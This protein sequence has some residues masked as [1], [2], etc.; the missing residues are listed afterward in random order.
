MG[1]FGVLRMIALVRRVNA[2][3]I[4]RDQTSTPAGGAT[5]RRF[6]S[7]REDGMGTI[8]LVE[9]LQN[10]DLIAWVDHGSPWR[11]CTRWLRSNRDISSGSQ[12]IPLNDLAFSAI[13][14][15]SAGAHPRDGVLVVSFEDCL[16]CRLLHLRRRVK[17]GHSLRRLIA[18]YLWASRVI[19][20]ITDSVKTCT[21][22]AKIVECG[23]TFPLVTSHRQHN[24]W[25]CSDLY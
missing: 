10:N 9:R 16:R 7:R 14:R 25:L 17:V 20:R 15:R 21:R 6:G 11:T 24:G 1:L 2:R 4:H 8:V 3:A 22:S 19:S 13:A 5:Q 12:A 23:K 18:P